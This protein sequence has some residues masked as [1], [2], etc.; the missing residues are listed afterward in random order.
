MYGSSCLY[1]VEECVKLLGIVV[2]YGIY[3]KLF[4]LEDDGRV[5]YLVVVEKSGG[6]LRVI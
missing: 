2:F 6:W 4:K 3:I 5:Y 1:L